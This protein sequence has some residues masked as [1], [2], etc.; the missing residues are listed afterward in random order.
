MTLILNAGCGVLQPMEVIG[1][2]GGH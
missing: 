2:T 1:V